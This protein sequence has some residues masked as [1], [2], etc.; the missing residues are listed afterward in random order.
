MHTWPT[1]QGGERARREAGRDG[2][3]SKR[4]NIAQQ[5]KKPQNDEVMTLIFPPEAGSIFCGSE[6]R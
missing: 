6:K 1:R 2:I 3:R 5:N 4:L